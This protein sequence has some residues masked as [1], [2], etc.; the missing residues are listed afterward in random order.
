MTFTQDVT[1]VDSTDFSP[2]ALG[3]LGSTVSGVSGSGSVYTVTVATGS[4]SGSIRLNVLDDDTIV[5]AFANPL[6]GAGVDNGT[7]T[8]GETYTINKTWIFGDVPNTY[9][10]HGYIERLYTAGITGGCTAIPLNYCPA[11]PVTRAQMAIFLLRGMHGSAYAPPAATGTKFT[12]CLR[13]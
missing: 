10:S 11:N 12:D 2:V 7:F 4:G 8:F 1:G 6:G 5:N 13:K 3:V 9:W